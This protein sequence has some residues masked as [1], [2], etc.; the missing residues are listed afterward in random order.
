MVEPILSDPKRTGGIKAHGGKQ[1]KREEASVIVERLYHVMKHG[2]VE[3]VLTKLH[4]LNCNFAAKG[5]KKGTGMME[6]YHFWYDEDL[7]PDRGAVRR[8]PCACNSCEET[9][10]SPWN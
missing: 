1:K 10:A 3:E 5:W 8:V 7:G 6:S 4:L 2:N 9:L